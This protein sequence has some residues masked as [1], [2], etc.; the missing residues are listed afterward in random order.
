MF[1]VVCLLSRGQLAVL[2]LALQAGAA[3]GIFAASA[4]GAPEIRLPWQA[5]SSAPRPTLP[6]LPTRVQNPCSRAFCPT[7]GKISLSPSPDKK[8]S[9]LSALRPI[10]HL[11]ASSYCSASSTS[12]FKTRGHLYSWDQPHEER[13]A[14]GESA[15]KQLLRPSSASGHLLISAMVR[16]FPLTMLYNPA[17]GCCIFSQQRPPSPTTES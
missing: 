14:H 2:C 9:P 5:S 6:C 3:L 4:K 15:K 17:Y 8:P 12:L 1:E 13:V 16:R 10:T 11:L 7:I